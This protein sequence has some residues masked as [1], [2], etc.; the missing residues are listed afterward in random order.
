MWNNP[1]KPPEKVTIPQ[2]RQARERRAK[3]GFVAGLGT[4]LPGRGAEAPEPAVALLVFSKAC[5]G[6]VPPATMMKTRNALLQVFFTSIQE[7][8]LQKLKGAATRSQILNRDRKKPARDT[9][10]RPI[11]RSRWL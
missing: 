6:S 11:R 3:E 10:A 2:K 7:P 5:N 9:S 8:R 4:Q 1:A